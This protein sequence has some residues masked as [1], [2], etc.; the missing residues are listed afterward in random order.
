MTTTEMGKAGTTGTPGTATDWIGIVRELGPSFAARAAEHDAHDAFVADNYAALKEHGI[1]K[2]AVPAELGGGGASIGDLCGVIREL[3]HHCSSTALAASM[4]THS[5]AMM[6]SA[7][8]A[9]TRRPSR[10]SAA[11]PPRGSCWS[12]PAAPTGWP[13]PAG[14]R[15]SRAA[16]R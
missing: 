12:A 5:V 6:S 10:C 13:D 9:E 8:A 3:G 7:G 11:W 4:H 14:W 16:T 1:F 2:A 15:R